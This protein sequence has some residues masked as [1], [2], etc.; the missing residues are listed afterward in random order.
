MQVNL[1]GVE[2]SE[3]NANEFANF[4]YLSPNC[5]CCIPERVCDFIFIT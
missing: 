5:E 3:E 2:G 1:A 4:S